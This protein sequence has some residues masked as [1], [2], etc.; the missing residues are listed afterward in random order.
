MQQI[1]AKITHTARNEL[2]RDFPNVEDETEAFLIKE[3]INKAMIK[4]VNFA[5]GVFFHGS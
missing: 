3:K 1:I 5:K 2:I 4:Q